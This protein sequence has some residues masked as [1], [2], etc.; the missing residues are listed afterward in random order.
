VEITP[1]IISRISKPHPSLVIARIFS[2]AALLSTVL[3]VTLIRNLPLSMPLHPSLRASVT[4]SVVSHRQW[5]FVEPLV[6]QLNRLCPETVAKIVLTVNA[7]EEIAFR[8]SW[9]LPIERV[10]NAEPKGFGAN[11]NAAFARCDTSWFLILNPDIRIDSDIF[12]SLLAKASERTGLLT[13]RIQ[14]PGSNGPEPYRALLTPLEL[15]RRRRAGHRPPARP[16]WV[17]GMF[18]LLRRRAF[19]EIGGFDERYFMYCEDADLCAR[20]RLA[21]WQLWAEP[22][23]SVLHLAQ[24]ASRAQLRPFAWHLSSLLKLWTSPVFWRYRQLL[25]AESQ[26]SADF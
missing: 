12:P 7:P 5:A 26:V 22:S 16:A 2:G 17:A 20:L 11:H 9:Q 13:P 14:E 10:Q 18:M 19:A 24:R 8:S 15:A 4:V 23:V 21:D 3:R 1:Q 6:D 25:Q